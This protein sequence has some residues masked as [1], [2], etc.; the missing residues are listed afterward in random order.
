MTRSHRHLLIGALA[1]LAATALLAPATRSG[2]TTPVA[3]PPLPDG[4]RDAWIG[5][6]PL[7][8]DA[9]RGDVVLLNVWTYGCGNCSRS[10]PWLKQLHARFAGRDFEIVGVH[11]PEFAWEKRRSAVVDAVERHGIAYP[12]VMDNDLAYWSRLDNRYWPAFYLVD[13]QGRISARFVGETHAGDRQ[14]R[15]IEEAIERLLDAS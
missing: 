11:S 3:A 1:L 12:V 4:D 14:A 5:S 9:L 6:V 7:T 15:A 10:I 2:A 13:R 8:W